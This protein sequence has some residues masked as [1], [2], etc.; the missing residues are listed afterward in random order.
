MA[1]QHIDQGH[2][3]R[4]VLTHPL[5]GTL[6]P[7]WFMAAFALSALA[8]RGELIERLVLALQINTILPMAEP[9]LGV[10][11][12]LL[13]ALG[14]G[15]VGALLGHLVLRWLVGDAAPQVQDDKV[16]YRRRRAGDGHPDAPARRPIHAHDEL[17]A[18]GFDH[19]GHEAPAYEP[20]PYQPEPSYIPAPAPAAAVEPLVLDTAL[21]LAPVPAEPAPPPLAELNQ[22]APLSPLDPVRGTPLT[23][24]EAHDISSAPVPSPAPR[25][26]VVAPEEPEPLEPAPVIS[27]KDALPLR[28]IPRMVDKPLPVPVPESDAAER[29]TSAPLD[30]LGHVE[31]IERLA[32]AMQRRQSATVAAQQQSGVVEA[33]PAASQQGSIPANDQ[34]SAALRAALA[35]LRQ[36]Q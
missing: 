4:R 6:V 15:L 35:G 2:D 31:L 17:G 10:T 30:A 23:P 25:V 12:R 7:V 16:D 32:V 19:T 27:A 1:R 26:S 20:V 34:T 14:F 36:V 33:N 8:V 3:W 22:P 29:L 24:Y 13:I 11:A 5:M 28:N 18:Y 21:P 9:P